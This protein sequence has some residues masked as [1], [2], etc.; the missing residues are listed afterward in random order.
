MTERKKRV[1]NT[2]E[3]DTPLTKK[4]IISKIL[5]KQTKKKFLTDS[6]KKYYETCEAL[7]ESKGINFKQDHELWLKIFTYMIYKIEP[8]SSK[9]LIKSLFYNFD[10]S[11]W[12]ALHL[13]NTKYAKFNQKKLLEEFKSELN[14][15]SD[16]LSFDR[17]FRTH[18]L[19]LRTYNKEINQR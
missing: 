11:N 8:K 19:F 2:N 1:S 4:E 9:E 6:Q 16:R 13:E 18:Y 17:I 15:I 14:Y 3:N 5:N 12:T 7:C 10:M